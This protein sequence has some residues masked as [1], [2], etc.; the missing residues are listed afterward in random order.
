MIEIQDVIDETKQLRCQLT[1]VTEQRDNLSNINAALRRERDAIA[2][3]FHEHAH[4][5]LS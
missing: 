5:L 1:N 2:E 3:K 4:G